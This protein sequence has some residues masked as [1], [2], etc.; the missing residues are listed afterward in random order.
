MRRSW[1]SILSTLICFRLAETGTPG[2]IENLVQR[3][4]AVQ[5][6][7]GRTMHHSFHGNLRANRR[8]QDGVAGGAD[9]VQS[10]HLADKVVWIQFGAPFLCRGS[11]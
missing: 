7:D 11:V 4:L 5:L 10:G 9:C 6:V 3:R 2:E 1:A 8:Y